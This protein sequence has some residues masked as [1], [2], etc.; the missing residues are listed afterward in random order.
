M[1]GR[2]KLLPKATEHLLE[3]WWF[4]S[5]F[6]RVKVLSQRLKKKGVRYLQRTH[7]LTLKALVGEVTKIED[8]YAEVRLK[9]KNQMRVGEYGLINGGFTFGLTDYVAMLAVNE[10]TVVLG[11]ANVKFTK[12]VWIGDEIFAQAKVLSVEVRKRIVSAEAFNH[13]GEKVLK[14]SFHCYILESE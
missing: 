1:R 5:F 10:H 9:T 4:K 14:G 3:P 6:K 12:P 11:K 8:H 2:F 7:K 13:K